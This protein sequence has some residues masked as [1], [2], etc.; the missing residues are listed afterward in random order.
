MKVEIFDE[1]L[2][3]FLGSLDEDTIGKVLRVEE[4]LTSRQPIGDA[5]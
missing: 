4:F 2:E 3:K 5:A 1:R